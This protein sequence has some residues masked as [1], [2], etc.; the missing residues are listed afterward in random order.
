MKQINEMFLNL[1]FKQNDLKC[2]MVIVETGFKMCILEKSKKHKVIVPANF[3]NTP[4]FYTSEKNILL[5]CN[6]GTTFI[7]ILLN[8]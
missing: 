4:V 5:T 2:M 6:P 7:V 3:S 1:Y 8:H